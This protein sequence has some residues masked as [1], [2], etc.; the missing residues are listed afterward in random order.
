MSLMQSDWYHEG[1]WERGEGSNYVRYGNDPGWVPTVEVLQRFLKPGSHLFEVASAKGWF[2]HAA[3]DAGFDARGMDISDYAVSQATG[4]VLGRLRQGNVAEV[5]IRPLRGYS[6]VC[7]WEF[8]EHVPVDEL[9]AVLSNMERALV[10][11]G[12]LWHRI[13]ID[14]GNAEDSHNH[15]ADVTHQP[16]QTRQWWEEVFAERGL[17]RQS[18][19]E[20]ALQQKF[21]SRDWAERFFVYRLRA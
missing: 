13:G 14:L 12:W 2:L 20:R 4:A 16:E 11:G 18:D 10:S 5:P 19:A 1:Y 7:S 15:Q 21:A 17:V 8:L 9:D 6:A 3:L